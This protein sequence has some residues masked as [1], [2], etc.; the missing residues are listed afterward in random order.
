MAPSTYKRE[1]IEENVDRIVEHFMTYC[2]IIH[3]LNF[4]D[5]ITSKTSLQMGA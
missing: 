4:K 2:N 3:L 5:K 1:G